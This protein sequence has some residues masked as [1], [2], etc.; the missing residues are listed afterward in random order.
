[1]IMILSFSNTLHNV[2][3]RSLRVSSN[4]QEY[5]PLPVRIILHKIICTTS[6]IIYV[7]I[8]NYALS[9][10]RYL[11]HSHA[12]ALL[13][14]L[15]MHGCLLTILGTHS[16]FHTHLGTLL[17]MNISYFEA[18]HTRS[19]NLLDVVQLL[20]ESPYAEERFRLEGKLDYC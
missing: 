3:A 2:N 7:L 5:L 15:G 13:T 4:C 19:T 6:A 14:I 17:H 9:F 10:S 20:A 12:T 11:V 16:M 1:M 8:Q 18:K